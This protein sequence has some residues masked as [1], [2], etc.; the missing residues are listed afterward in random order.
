MDHLGQLQEG[1]EGVL[2]DHPEP[3]E[4]EE[5]CLHLGSAEAVD[6]SQVRRD[7]PPIRRGRRLQ[8]PS[9]LLVESQPRKSKS[10]QSKNSLKLPRRRQSQS[11]R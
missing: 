9:F 1:A 4:E 2:E 6:S 7:L 5:A 11:N 8:T 3:W 10:S